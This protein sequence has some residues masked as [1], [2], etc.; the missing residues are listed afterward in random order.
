MTINTIEN[1]DGCIW[2]MKDN[3]TFMY[4]N[5]KGD[6]YVNGNIVAFSNNIDKMYPPPKE[7]K[8]KK[9]TEYFQPI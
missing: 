3:H 5:D 7:L 9:I 8:S 1:A 2:F 4:F 6:M